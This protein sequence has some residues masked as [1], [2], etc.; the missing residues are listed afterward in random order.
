MKRAVH[1]LTRGLPKPHL[2]FI[3]IDV[4]AIIGMTTLSELRKLI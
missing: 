4:I 3:E 1:H 2:S